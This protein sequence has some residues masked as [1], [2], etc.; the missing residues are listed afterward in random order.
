[1]EVTR[2]AYIF[3]T[4]ATDATNQ[5]ISSNS[6]DLVILKHRDLNTDQLN[7]YVNIDAWLYNVHYVFVCSAVGGVGDKD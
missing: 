2:W 1:M 4:V 3:Y 6:F 5:G 7:N